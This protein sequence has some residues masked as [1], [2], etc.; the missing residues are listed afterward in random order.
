MRPAETAIPM[1]D[2]TTASSRG[3]SSQYSQRHGHADPDEE[4]YQ[5]RKSRFMMGAGGSAIVV[6]SIT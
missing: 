5:R 6:R 4:K 1:V 2:Y 3:G